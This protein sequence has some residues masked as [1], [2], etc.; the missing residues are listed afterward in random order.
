[1]DI[2]QLRSAAPAWKNTLQDLGLPSTR[3]SSP[4]FDDSKTM[5][6]P[7]TADEEC[8]D[9]VQFLRNIIRREG[10]SS[11]SVLKSIVGNMLRQTNPLDPPTAIERGVIWEAGEGGL[12]EVG[13]P[14]D[15]TT[16]VF[17]AISLSTQIPMALSDV[18]EKN[19]VCKSRKWAALWINQAVEM[20]D[21]VYHKIPGN[22]KAKIV[23]LASHLQESS[24]PFPPDQSD[25]TAEQNAI[26]EMLWKDG[27]GWANRLDVIEILKKKF[28]RMKHP[29]MRTK[30][31]VAKGP[32]G[33]TVGLSEEDAE[34]G[35]ASL[36]PDKKF[37]QEKDIVGSSEH[38]HPEEESRSSDTDSSDDE[39]SWRQ[40]AR[41][42]PK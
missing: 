34:L 26:F 23:C 6:E 30:L 24:R 12:K 10:A 32:Y 37:P 7:L 33:H 17:P 40:L 15:E 13:L 31:Y 39:D 16:G 4:S 1:M 36:C 8:I 9:D 28:P 3:D 41:L 38:C 19:W 35:L 22:S 27:R 5:F 21:V 42:A 29:Y 20:G 14:I 25:T 2:L 11:G 18:P